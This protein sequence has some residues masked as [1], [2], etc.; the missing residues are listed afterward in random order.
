M[1]NWVILMLYL[2]KTAIKE[3]W[4]FEVKRI[5]TI[6]IVICDTYISHGCSTALV[7]FP[8]TSVQPQIK[9]MLK[10]LMLRS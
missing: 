7:L 5:S 2:E 10:M 8:G 6:N 1:G 4:K 9:G 3:L